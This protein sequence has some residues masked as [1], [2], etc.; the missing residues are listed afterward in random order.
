[1][2][3]QEQRFSKI[4]EFLK[5]TWK[6]QVLALIVYLVVGVE[7]AKFLWMTL[8]DWNYSRHFPEPSFLGFLIGTW[9][10]FLL[11]VFPL[12][13]LCYLL[14]CEVIWKSFKRDRIKKVK[15]WEIMMFIGTILG[16]GT[17]LG[18]LGGGLLFE[19]Y[20]LYPLIP[21]LPAL[22]LGM[23]GIALII[24]Y[25]GIISGAVFGILIGL[26]ISL[27]TLGYNKLK[28]ISHRRII[29]GAIIGILVGL[30]VSLIII[31]SYLRVYRPYMGIIVI[32]IGVSVALIVGL[33]VNLII[34]IYN[35]LKK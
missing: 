12:F 30:I 34:L 10:P 8:E 26:I 29:F 6:K 11:T 14:S 13:A 35:K 19:L 3:V 33:I 21:G 20:E 17:P 5:P 24:L 32:V 22:P 28:M 2:E 4:K 18:L 16:C 25:G 23:T 15:V 1:M 27:I 9:L 31:I 7:I